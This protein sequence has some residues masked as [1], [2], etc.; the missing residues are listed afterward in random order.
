MK[1][2]LFLCLPFCSFAQQADELFLRLSQKFKLV[3]H[4][5]VVAQIKPNIP[6][7][8]IFPEKS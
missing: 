3:Q 2:F 5:E 6:F 8:K 7:I 4:Y 1:Y